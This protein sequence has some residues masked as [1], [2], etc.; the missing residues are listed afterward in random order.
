MA[1]NIQIDDNLR[2]TSK[3]VCNKDS[4][5]IQ[6]IKYVSY[7]VKRNNFDFGLSRIFICNKKFIPARYRDIRYTNILYT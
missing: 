3:L 7:V 5:N 4:T 1:Y 6:A 2:K